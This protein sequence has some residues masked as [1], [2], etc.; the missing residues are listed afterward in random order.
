MD[1][2]EF[3]QA[4]VKCGSV[5]RH[6]CPF[7][8][9]IAPIIV[10]I[11][12]PESLSARSS[13]KMSV[14]SPASFVVPPP[15]EITHVQELMQH[16]IGCPDACYV[17]CVAPAFRNHHPVCS[18]ESHC[19]GARQGTPKC[20]QSHSNHRSPC[21]RLLP[22]MRCTMVPCTNLIALYSFTQCSDLCGSEEYGNDCQVKKRKS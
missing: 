2:C 10:T 1:F 9:A 15:C 22:S 16:L 12:F 3:F 4:S 5:F 7:Q 8:A 18:R 14:A 19:F 11:L 13:G 6:R 20:S 21:L 17:T